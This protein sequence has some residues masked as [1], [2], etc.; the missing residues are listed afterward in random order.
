VEL[1]PRLEAAVAERN[2]MSTDNCGPA[3]ERI[4]PVPG[5]TITRVPAS[6]VETRPKL[7]GLRD[8]GTFHRVL[9]ELGRASGVMAFFLDGLGFCIICVVFSFEV[10]FTFAKTFARGNTHQ[11]VK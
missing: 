8:M 10:G 1:E 11:C 5:P 3:T 2:Q 9:V 7:S 6:G 4:G